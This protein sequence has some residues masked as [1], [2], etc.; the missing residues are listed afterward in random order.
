MT[1]INASVLGGVID[2]AGAV[3]R[4]FGTL[5]RGSQRSFWLNNGAPVRMLKQARLLTCPTLADIS[6]SRPESAKPASLPQDAPTSSEAA[7]VCAYL[8]NG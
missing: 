4:E 1:S 2:L 6:P 8:Q 7:A 5:A 3:C